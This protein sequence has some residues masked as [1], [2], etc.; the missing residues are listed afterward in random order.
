MDPLVVELAS[1]ATALRRAA[2][3]ERTL[4]EVVLK[5]SENFDREALLEASVASAAAVASF[6]AS[7]SAARWT[8]SSEP[9]QLVKMV[10]LSKAGMTLAVW[11]T[12]SSSRE[13]VRLLLW[14]LMAPANSFELGAANGIAPL[15][16]TL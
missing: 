4:L 15:E 2:T 7:S 6:A 12:A 13:M 8:A 14:K 1:E 11:A 9:E 5:Y 16:T 3:E 10:R